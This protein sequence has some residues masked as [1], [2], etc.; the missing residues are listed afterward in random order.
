LPK[1]FFSFDSLPR[2]LEAKLSITEAPDM[3]NLVIGSFA[4]ALLPLSLAVLEIATSALRA[5][6]SSLLKD[7]DFTSNGNDR[8][9]QG[10]HDT[11]VDPISQFTVPAASA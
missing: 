10:D 8:A 5:W 4:L 2:R 7:A 1:I 3:I 11:W 9:F 6:F